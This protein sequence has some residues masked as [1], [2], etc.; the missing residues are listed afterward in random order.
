MTY[1]GYAYSDSRPA[2]PKHVYFIRAVGMVGPIKIGITAHVDQRL[3]YLMSWS[4]IPLEVAALTPGTHVLEKFLHRHFR[5]QKLQNE[6]FTATPELIAVIDGLNAGK[7]IAEATGLPVLAS[8]VYL[9]QHK[10][11][12]HG[13]AAYKLG[14]PTAALMTAIRRMEDGLPVSKA[15]LSKIEAF[16]VS[17]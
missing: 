3:D 13:R 1:S 9:F 7:T 2:E 11:G 4:P 15:L 12:G 8:P 17:Q 10:H 16:E 5:A 14:V 6:W